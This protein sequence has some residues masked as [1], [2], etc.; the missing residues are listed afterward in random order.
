MRYYLDA[1]LDLDI[2]V[3]ARAIGVDIVS[4]HECDASTLTDEAQL[5][6]A[7][8]ERRCVVTFNRDDFL[9]VTRMAYDKSAPHC[10]VLI[11]LPQWRYSRHGV[12][13][14]A[15]ATHSAR[16]PEDTLPVY[17]IAFLTYSDP[18]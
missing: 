16:F 4:A 6:R 5:A 12:I 18:A 3:A 14:K 1:D 15:L 10:G 13:A 9:A 8:S 17:T 7:A 11:V 2:A